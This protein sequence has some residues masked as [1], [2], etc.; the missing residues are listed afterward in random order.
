M[1]PTFKIQ[2]TDTV[3]ANAKLFIEAGLQG[4]SWF[5]IDKGKDCVALSSYHFTSAVSLEG[6]ATI[7]KEMVSGN[8]LLQVKFESITI[9][10]AYPAS[11]LV[12]GQLMEEAAKKEMLELLYGDIADEYIRTD[13]VYKQNLYNIYTVPKQ[14]DAVV[15]YIF[16]GEVSTHLYSLLPDI[17]TSTQNHLYCIFGTGYFTAML[18]KNGKLQSI[19]SWQFKTPEDVAYYLLQYCGAFE[20]DIH[21]L[22]VH[23]NGMIDKASNLYNELNKYFLHLQFESLPQQYTYPEEMKDYP[24]HY[25]SH[26]F[27]LATCV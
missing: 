14:I 9:V 4:I 16:S 24:Q 27:A 15:S 26:L 17:V 19:Q 18:L 7:L 12:P 1:N 2:S 6:A 21:D 13:F 8:P 23:L 20:A 11:V 3:T 10:Y 5:V 22:A 25:F